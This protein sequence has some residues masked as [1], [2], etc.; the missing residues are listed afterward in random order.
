MALTKVVTRG[1]LFQLTTEPFT[2]F[3]PFTVRVKPVVV[4]DGVAF[5]C[6]VEDDNEVMDG[7]RTVN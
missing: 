6:V 5:D 1:E 7:G 4:Q 2:K 3:V